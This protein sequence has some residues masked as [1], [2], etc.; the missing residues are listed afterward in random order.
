MAVKLDVQELA[1]GWIRLPLTYRMSQAPLL[2]SGLWGSQPI[3]VSISLPPPPP[4]WQCRRDFSHF[5]PLPR[6]PSF[7]I[8]FL[9]PLVTSPVTLGTFAQ[10][11]CGTLWDPLCI[12]TPGK[13]ASTLYLCFTGGT[14]RAGISPLL[15]CVPLGC[16]YVFRDAR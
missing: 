1:A 15:L 13:Y 7:W 3:P 4:P 9:F 6:V 14:P 8:L 2:S 12:S 11:P 10:G 16:V 5:N